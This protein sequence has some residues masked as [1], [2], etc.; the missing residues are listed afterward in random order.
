[1]DSESQVRQL[2]AALLEQAES[3]A[4]EQRTAAVSA[5]ER[6]LADSAERLKIAEER[7]ILSAKIEAERLVRRQTQSAETRLAAELDRLRWALTETTL[8]RVQ[9]AFRE[10]TT[11][12]GRYLPVLESWLAVAAQQLPPGD[13]QVAAR[14][15][16]LSLLSVDWAARAARLAPGRQA[17][18]VALE[19]PSEGGLLVRLADGRAQL[20]QTFEARQLRLAEELARVIMERLFASAP[21]L[22]TLVHG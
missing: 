12:A 3:L 19:T 21:D 2:E 14:P 16:D 1:M 7:E 15:A 4:R 22:G 9:Q 10:L 11:D 18:L 20:D 5:R 8:A 13:L 17:E 6:V